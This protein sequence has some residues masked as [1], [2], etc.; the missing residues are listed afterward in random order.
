MENKSEDMKE[1][2]NVHIFKYV[3]YQESM[4][5]G[6]VNLRLCCVGDWM[7]SCVCFLF[8]FPWDQ[9]VEAA[10]RKYPNPHSSSVHS[11]DTLERRVTAAPNRSVG[12]QLY[13]H[14]IF[15]TRWNV[16]SL[17]MK[18]RGVWCGGGTKVWG[19]WCGDGTKVRGVW[20][21]GGTK[22]RGVWCR[23]GTKLRGVWCGGGMKV[24]VIGVEPGVG[25]LLVAH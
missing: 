21:R 8:S 6:E 22:V 19:V 23:G 24:I 17:V 13:S 1:W 15:S 4:Y 11:L 25:K 12:T 14:R 9:M 2:A 20:C 10:Y 7:S 5:T 18:V 16:P 3:P